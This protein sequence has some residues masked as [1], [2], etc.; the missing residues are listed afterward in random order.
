MKKECFLMNMNIKIVKL[1][2]EDKLYLINFFVVE[3]N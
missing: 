2:D 3:I 1:G